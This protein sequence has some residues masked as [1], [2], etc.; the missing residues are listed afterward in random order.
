[1]QAKQVTLRLA[2]SEHSV[3]ACGLTCSSLLINGKIL[4]TVS[5]LPHIKGRNR[6]PERFNNSAG[7]HSCS[8]PGLGLEN[9]SLWDTKAVVF[10]LNPQSHINVRFSLAQPPPDGSVATGGASQH[11]Q[12][13]YLLNQWHELSSFCVL[14][15]LY[16]AHF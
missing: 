10:S 4:E 15:F 6:I 2:A 8:V 1:M 13:E 9:L 12:D 7:S 11:I 5:T 16:C 14:G 3:S